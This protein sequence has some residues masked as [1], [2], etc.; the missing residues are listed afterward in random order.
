MTAE[1]YKKNG[2]GGFILVLVLALFCAAAGR[3]GAAS[4]Y[5][6]STPATTSWGDSSDWSR[7]AA[8]GT[9]GAP[10]SSATSADTYVF[11][12][13]TS[14]S[15][16]DN[17]SGLTLGSLSFTTNAAAYTLGGNAFSLYKG[18]PP[19]RRPPRRSAPG[20]PSRGPTPGMSTRA[21]R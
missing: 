13:S 16:N 4:Y 14:T 2:R 7:Y 8:T 12:A 17:L 9:N 11:D 19:A 1:G 10:S 5:W 15:L 18:S 6:D 21:A 3:A 20:S